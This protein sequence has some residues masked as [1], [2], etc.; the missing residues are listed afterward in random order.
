MRKKSSD[1]A[2]Y[3]LVLFILVAVIVYIVQIT[4]IFSS[5]QAFQAT[6]QQANPGTA[7]QSKRELIFFNLIN[8]I[9]LTGM[10]WC[11]Q[12]LYSKKQ[13]QNELKRYAISAYRR[14]HDIFE[15]VSVLKSSI[16]QTKN[17]N[18]PAEYNVAPRFVLQYG[19]DYSYACKICRIR[20]E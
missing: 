13:Y 4:D 17:Q 3:L 1:I 9:C 18:L 10:G 7:V 15:S 19:R 16:M 8:F 14:I 12:S 20:L 2:I 11:L 6:T 5:T